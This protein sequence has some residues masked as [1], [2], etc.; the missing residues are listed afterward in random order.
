MLPTP[1]QPVPARRMMVAVC[2]VGRALLYPCFFLS[3]VRLC[4]REMRARTFPLVFAM[5][6]L[7]AIRAHSQLVNGQSYTRGLAIVDAPFPGKYVPDV[8]ACTKTLIFPCRSPYHAGAN[9]PIAIEVSGNGNIAWPPHDGASTS[10]NAL[11]LFLVSAPL[12]V[13]W[14][15]AGNETFFKGEEGNTVKHLDLSIPACVPGGDYNFT[16]YET[17]KWEDKPYFSISTIPISIESTSK[18]K[19]D[20]SEEVRAQSFVVTEPEAQPQADAPWAQ[21]G[22]SPISP[23]IPPP[24]SAKGKTFAFGALLLAVVPALGSLA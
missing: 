16:L 11:T 13:N 18:S 9:L 2:G 17:Y 24:S 22:T 6:V 1:A 12:G 3:Q 10:I 19:D 15:V 7:S 23:G 14:T 5:L 8:T 21:N 4:L 20:C